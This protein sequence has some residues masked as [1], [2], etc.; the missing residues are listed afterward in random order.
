VNA[1][2]YKALTLWAEIEKQLGDQEKAAYYGNAAAKLATSFNKNIADG[3]LWDPEK[4]CYVH[5]RDKGG[6]AHGNNMVTPVNFMAISY[7][8]C[9]D[10]SR[11]KTIL[12][13]IEDLMVKE[14]LFFWPL[15]LTSY[16]P[17]EG[18]DW[19]YPFPNYE[20]GDIFLSWGATAVHAYAGYKPEIAIKYIRKVLDQYGKD[21]L[22]FQRY[23]RNSQAGLGDDI[24]AGNALSVVGLYQSVYG[25]NPLY[26]RFYLDPHLT[27]ELYGTKLKY[28]FRGQQ[29]QIELN[30]SKYSVNND[31]FHM[32]AATDFGF[33]ASQNE[34][35]F[36]NKNNENA[37]LTLTASG[38]EMISLHIKNWAADSYSWQQKASPKQNMGYVIAGCT[39]GKK[40]EIKA[41]EK[42]IGSK[43]ADKN[44]QL[45]FTHSAGTNET[46]FAV[47]PSR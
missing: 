46:D 23:G 42:V 19:Q 24:L 32:S 29:L 27:P 30:E 10:E 18:K 47:T 33:N 12:D 44:G 6:E 37:D 39:P 17:G 41:G 31:R 5:W 4:K 13:A 15:T 28:N 43:Q 1:K 11:K 25:I 14:N 8:I 16:A 2:L 9:Q 40:Y 7:G 38:S 45:T 22:A 3:G 21:G 20:N 26:N 34:V 36:F 35:R